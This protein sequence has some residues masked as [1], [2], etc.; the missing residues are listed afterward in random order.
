MGQR[1]ATA[2]HLDVG[3]TGELYSEENDYTC[4]YG[5]V[6]N[7]ADGCA[8]KLIIGD[9]GSRKQSKSLQLHAR[10]HEAHAS[11]STTPTPSLRCH[12]HEATNT[13]PAIMI[14]AV[15]VF[16]NNGQPRLTKFYTQLV[17]T[18]PTPPHHLPTTT[19]RKPPNTNP[20][21]QQSNNASSPRSSPS[22]PPVQPAA[23]TSCPSHPS[24]RPK[25]PP[26]P[27]PTTPPPS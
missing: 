7:H 22:S 27:N 10:S 5:V 26:P 2:L 17:C 15:L 25:A 1:S 24:S 11:H 16:N 3:H 14:N 4:S 19:S 9:S 21:T 12:D 23:A 20:R 18:S 6:V 13:T 8:L